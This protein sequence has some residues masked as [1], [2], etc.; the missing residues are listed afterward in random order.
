M[1]WRIKAN[2]GRGGTEGEWRWEIGRGDRVAQVVVEITPAALAADPRALAEDTRRARETDGRAPL[3]EILDVDDPPRRIR[4]DT[5]GCRHVIENTNV[6]E[7]N[8]DTMKSIAQL[9]ARLTN[10]E[11]IEDESTYSPEERRFY[12]EGVEGYQAD[13]FTTGHLGGK[14]PDWLRDDEH[15]RS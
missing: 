4:C 8:R 13:E 11:R 9:W 12:S 6:R 10:R 2:L 3:L 1:S 14:E 5:T 15:H 7:E